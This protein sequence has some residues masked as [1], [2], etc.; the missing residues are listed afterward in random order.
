[1]LMMLLMLGGDGDTDGYLAVLCRPLGMRRH[2][3]QG[4]LRYLPNEQ[5]ARLG[6]VRPFRALCTGCPGVWGVPY[7]FRHQR[8]VLSGAAHDTYLDLVYCFAR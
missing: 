2:A 1:M 7:P 6:S 4:A 5:A 3:G 8:C